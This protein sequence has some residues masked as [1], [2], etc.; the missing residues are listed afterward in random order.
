MSAAPATLHVRDVEK[1][2]SRQLGIG[3]QTDD[4]P[5][6]R[7]HM[8]NLVIYCDR[9]DAA[10]SL[11]NLIP[12]VVELHPARVLLLVGQSASEKS[13]IDAEVSVWC[14]K[15]RGGPQACSELI[16]LRAGGAAVERLPFSVRG[17]LIGDLPTNIWWQ[18][19]SPPPLA[20]PLL[21]DLAENAEQV[22]YDSIGWREPAQAVAATAEWQSRFE[23]SRDG[24]WRVASD[25]NWR[26]LKY[27]R[28]LTAQALDPMTAPGAL[29]SI[30]EIAIDH[31]PHAVVQA[32][33]LASWLAT[34]LGWRVQAGHLQPGVSIDWKLG[35]K[36]G[37]VKIVLHRLG[38]GPSEVRSMR[39]A[40]KLDGKSYALTFSVPEKDR[41]AVIPEDTAAAPRT[42][43]APSSPLAELVARQLSDRERDGVF[44]ESMATA[45]E[46]ARA[47]LG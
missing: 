1:E 14:R 46:M 35:A 45:F 33:L 19:L 20:G 6:Q 16:T 23:R 24:R 21:S 11:T 15:H 8:S 3:K 7:A 5:A 36:Q 2:L 43:T 10:E 30:T 25:L 27:W 9:A 42:L 17:L 44:R 29:E 37:H 26:R 41:L 18:C 31:G 40:F 13:E 32:L 47:V 39:I 22:V 12:A 34:R 38:D 28:R 4:A